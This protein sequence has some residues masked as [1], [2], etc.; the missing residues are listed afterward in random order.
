MVTL[1]EEFIY[2]C[3]CLWSFLNL[4]FCSEVARDP[5][6][7]VAANTEEFYVPRFPQGQ[8]LGKLEFS[9]IAGYWHWYSQE[10]EYHITTKI[11]ALV[12]LY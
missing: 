8:H 3:S 5:H 4:M 6:T 12:L 10:T 11:S 2:F 7:V 1:Q 9:I